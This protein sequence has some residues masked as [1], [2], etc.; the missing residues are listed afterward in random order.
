MARHAEFGDYTPPSTSV[1]MERCFA[2]EIKNSTS[3]IAVMP[4]YE[5]HKIYPP[6]GGSAPSSGFVPAVVC[7]DFVPLSIARN[8]RANLA[9]A[10]HP[11]G[12]GHEDPRFSGDVPT[13]VPGVLRLGQQCGVCR[14]VD[15]LDP[16]IHRFGRRLDALEAVLARVG[17]AGGDPL[18]MLFDRH[19]HI[20]EHGG[21]PGPVIVNKFGKLAICSPK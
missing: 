21:L 17:D 3:L 10:R 2:A 13:E 7:D 8:A 9:V 15:V 11:A 5:I 19:R 4:G 18:D 12:I 1:V 14:L 6:G 16:P 20:A